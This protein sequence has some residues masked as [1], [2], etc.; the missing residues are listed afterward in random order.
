MQRTIEKIFRDASYRIESAEL[1]YGQLLHELDN[2]AYEHIQRMFKTNNNGEFY[3]AINPPA[4]LVVTG[5]ASVLAAKI[6][7]D[8]RSALDYSVSA[9]SIQNCP[10]FDESVPQFVIADSKERFDRDAKRRLKYLSDGQMKFIEQL[11]PF[12]GNVTLGLIRDAAN[13]TKHRRL[14][15]LQLQG[16]SEIHII[17]PS[18]KGK[19]QYRNWRIFK[20]QEG[21]VVAAKVK[22]HA[23]RFLDHY[24]AIQALRMMIDSTVDVI[25]AF[26]SH[27]NGKQP[28]P[29]V[30]Y[31]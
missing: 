3:I 8:L 11:Q 15:V 16:S 27:L 30:R 28:L 10:K 12:H 21:V 17:D 5:V 4:E 9:L 24:E 7:E 25:R 18:M 13:T 23:F 20:P 19:G 14:L 1:H 31:R 6:A 29:S 22:K 2:F 26:A